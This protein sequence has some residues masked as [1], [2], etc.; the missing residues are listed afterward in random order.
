MM[1]PDRTRYVP[2]M[3]D[4]INGEHGTVY[5]DD[6]VRVCVRGSAASNY[7]W[8]PQYDIFPFLELRAA[9]DDLRG[10]NGAPDKPFDVASTRKKIRAQL[11]TLQQ[12]GVRR[13]VLSAFGCGAFRNPATQVAALYKQELANFPVAFDHVVFAIYH[14]GYGPDNYQPFK[15]VFEGI[16]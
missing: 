7:A 16:N 9:A 15:D 3:T 12:A 11:I 13:V 2:A 6:G 4:L 8:L 10:S 1:T 5:L 14:A